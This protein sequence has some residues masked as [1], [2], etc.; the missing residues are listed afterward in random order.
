MAFLTSIDKEGLLSA[1]VGVTSDPNDEEIT[2]LV[3]GSDIDDFG[4]VR[5]LRG[6][7]AHKGVNLKEGEREQMIPHDK[8]VEKSTQFFPLK[9]QAVA[10]NV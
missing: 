8:I 6:N 1:T 7:F 3:T 2:T 5:V 4:N 9:P 10:V